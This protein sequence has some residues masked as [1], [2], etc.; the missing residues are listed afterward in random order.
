VG[1]CSVSSRRLV[2][3]STEIPFEPR[4]ASFFL[5]RVTKDFPSPFDVLDLSQLPALAVQFCRMQ[6]AK[7]RSAPRC[8]F[9]MSSPKHAPDCE[10]FLI[11]RH[12]RK[13]RR[14][15]RPQVSAI[16]HVELV[17]RLHFIRC[18]EQSAF[19]S[20]AEVLKMAFDHMAE[21]IETN[22][23][24]DNAGTRSI[25]A[26]N[27][28]GAEENERLAAA[29]RGNP[30]AFAEL[31]QAHA[32]RILRTTYRITRNREDAED[33]LQ[34]S[35]LRAFVHI[36][37]FDGR[38]SFSTWLTRIAI[39]SSL[40]ILRKRGTAVEISLD[41]AGERSGAPEVIN[42]PDRGPTPETRCAQRERDEILRSAI[43][44]LRPTIRQAL[45]LR[46]LQEHSLKETARIM[47]LS[48]TAAKSRLH[49][50]QVELRDL[51]KPKRIRRGRGAG[52]FH[53]QPAA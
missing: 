13:T 17:A 49:H 46:K 4:I 7:S 20:L 14:L 19:T 6:I 12:F 16:Q 44:E 28:F 48:V 47:G 8:N 27:R 9:S 5:Y 40:M 31:W 11:L 23:A 10:P 29:R 18:R 50:A 24:T 51:L 53:L 41:G 3:G 42:L 1:K 52:L 43:G 21:S 33:A 15:L 37:D 38:S 45:E 2:L 26:N 36:R 35:F 25:E 39:N 32:K 30:D 34:D 22:S